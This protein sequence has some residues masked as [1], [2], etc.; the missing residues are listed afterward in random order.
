[1]TADVP[2]TALE[3]SVTSPV[4]R[5]ALTVMERLARAKAPVG[6]IGVTYWTDGSHLSD[7]GIETVVLGPGDIADAHGPRDRVDVADLERAVDAYEG[8][9]NALLKASS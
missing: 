8:I 1:L 7:R 2:H 4:V 3:T 6:P 5:A 9:A